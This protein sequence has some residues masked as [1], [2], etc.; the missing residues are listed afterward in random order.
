MVQLM[1]PVVV[2]HYV[3]ESDTVTHPEYVEKAYK[4]ES[5]KR[6]GELRKQYDPDGVF[7][8]YSDGLD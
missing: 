8:S 4:A 7:F 2:G 6:L 5:L 3:A 1:S